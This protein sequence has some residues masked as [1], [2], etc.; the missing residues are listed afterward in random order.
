MLVTCVTFTTVFV[1]F[2]RVKYSRLV[3]YAGR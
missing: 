3:G 1:V 2:T